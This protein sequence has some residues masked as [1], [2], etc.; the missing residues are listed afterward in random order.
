LRR[1]K[2]RGRCDND[3]SARS[4]VTPFPPH[5]L[6]GIRHLLR[7]PGVWRI[8]C[9][10]RKRVQ[11]IHRDYLE[12]VGDLAPVSLVDDAV[13]EGRFNRAATLHGEPASRRTDRQQSGSIASEP[14]QDPACFIWLQFRSGKSRRQPFDAAPRSLGRPR[15]RRGPDVGSARAQD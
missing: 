12:K 7:F 2:R 13:S 10:E 5:A 4:H 3:P 1:N 14:F 15:C 6:T 8:K 11:T 9:Y